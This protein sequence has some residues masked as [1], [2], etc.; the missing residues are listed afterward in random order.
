VAGF[1]I[2]LSHRMGGFSASFLFWILCFTMTLL[3]I[4][5]TASTFP[6]QATAAKAGIEARGALG[7]VAARRRQKDGVLRG[8]RLLEN[9]FDVEQRCCLM[10]A[11]RQ[12]T[13]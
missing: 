11:E 5:A 7:D 6:C 3:F 8:E 12:A 4:C 2:P 13:R 1:V 10:V 9:G